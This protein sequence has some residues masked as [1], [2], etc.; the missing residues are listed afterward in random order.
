MQSQADAILP[1]NDVPDW[2]VIALREEPK[3]VAVVTSTRPRGNVLIQFNPDEG[4]FLPSTREVHLLFTPAALAYEYLATHQLED[5]PSGD[6]PTHTYPF[7][8]SDS[9][10]DRTW[11]FPAL[12]AIKLGLLK[13][14]YRERGY[15]DHGQTLIIEDEQH[16][17][18]AIWDNGG[19][20]GLEQLNDRE[21]LLHMIPLTRWSKAIPLRTVVY[22]LHCT[23]TDVPIDYDFD[24]PAELMA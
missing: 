20:L 18:F 8:S 23:L 13:L 15:L 19:E 4:V 6:L 3:R 7:L 10:R 22:R 9:K 11:Q 1:L 12:L 14:G 17:L 24:P 16:T 2:S 21:A 5:L